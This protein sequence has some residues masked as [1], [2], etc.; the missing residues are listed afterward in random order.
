MNDNVRSKVPVTKQDIAN[1]LGISRTAVSLA[2]NRSKK[3]TLS[4]K[5]I[6]QIFSAARE[7]GYHL[8]AREPNKKVC[9]AM[10]NMDTKVAID[11]N[12]IDVNNVDNYLSNLGYDVVSIYV[13]SNGRSLKQLF[14]SIENGDYIGIVLV[15]L[16]DK[17]ILERI[18]RY[19][20]PYVVLS[21][22]EDD[23]PNC[24]SYDTA[25]AA[26]VMTQTLIDYDHRRIVLFTGKL[27]FPQQRHILKGYRAALERNN[28]PF[29]PSMIQASSSENGQEVA[30]RMKYLDISYTAG[31]CSNPYIQIGVM[32]WLQSN[33]ISVPEQVSLI[34]YG[35]ADKSLIKLF[36]PE[37]S[38]FTQSDTEIIGLSQFS[39][40][41]NTGKKH[42]P[43]CRIQKGGVHQGGS[44][45]TAP[46]KVIVSTL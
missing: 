6:Q 42:F 28:I 43:C 30:A 29:D 26:D 45:A 17:E 9:I 18:N 39:E 15:A 21:D 20:L 44:I 3:C 16:L 22:M 23:Y 4:K 35:K 2:L 40:C 37:L 8:E 25:Y 7:L 19:D 38:I 14:S 10:F 12:R 1:Y 13:R 24:Y 11:T 36:S 31:V 33:G 5:N 46:V 27:D 32:N 34:S 41:L